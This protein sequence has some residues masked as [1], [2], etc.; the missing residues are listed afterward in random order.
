MFAFQATV[1]RPSVTV[2]YVLT[3][4]AQV[5]LRVQPL[6]GRSRAT[7]VANAGSNGKAGLNAIKWNRRLNRRKA[8][9]G[10]YRLTVTASREDVTA[11]SSITAR[12]R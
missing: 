3:H 10:R 1:K 2:R 12:L 8:P 4:S 7:V 11:T 9:P 6:S 5:T